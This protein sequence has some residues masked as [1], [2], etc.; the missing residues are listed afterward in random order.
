ME[1]KS[2]KQIFKDFITSVVEVFDNHIPVVGP[3]MDLPIVDE[4]EKK[5]VDVI[6]E[7]SWSVLTKPVSSSSS[8]SRF[9]CWSA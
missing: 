3:I 5:T 7:S 4:F 6:V 8:W 2:K 1:E 9:M